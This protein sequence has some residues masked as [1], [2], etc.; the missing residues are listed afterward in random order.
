M[1]GLMIMTA[2]TTATLA[3]AFDTTP[4]ELRKF[5]RSSA[6]GIESVGKGSR[7]TLPSTKREVAALNKRFA[8]WVEAKAPK[9]DPEVEAAEVEV[10]AEVAPEA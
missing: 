5:L 9:A 10:E 3:A 1:N 7:Y 4:R 6:S 8:A 2:N